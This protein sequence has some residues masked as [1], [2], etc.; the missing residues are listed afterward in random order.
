MTECEKRMRGTLTAT[1]LYN[2]E[3]PIFSAEM[4]AYGEGLSYLFDAIDSS[5]QDLFVQTAGAE[6]LKRF[7]K[8]FGV[9]PSSEDVQVRR[10]MLLT[11]GSVT[12]ADHT[13][14]DLETQL[15][16]AGIRGNIV[17]RHEGGLYV[18][19]Q[20]LLGVSKEAAE[21]EAEN[22]LPAHLPYVL[23]F[24][25]NTWNAI[26]SRELTFDEMDAAA[27]VWNQLDLR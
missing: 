4:A 12:P 8:L 24:G 16:G 2:G 13:K 25:V 11:R 18:N 26:D 1:G 17:E 20:E 15:F 22:F 9:M 6:Q 5:R 21:A 27:D 19:V 10:E 23:D 14:A 3:D 7:E